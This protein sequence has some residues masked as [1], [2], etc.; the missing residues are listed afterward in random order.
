M[1]RSR[2][3]VHARRSD[4]RDEETEPES[5]A[6]TL[7]GEDEEKKIVTKVKRKCQPEKEHYGRF[8]TVIAHDSSGVLDKVHPP[9]DDDYDDNSH[10]HRTEDHQ[11]QC[12]E[13]DRR[14]AEALR[15]CG[16]L[17]QSARYQHW[18][19][20]LELSSKPV[21]LGSMPSSERGNGEMREV[22]V[23]HDCA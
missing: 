5:D 15:S 20:F 22:R 6:S 13:R 10:R 12:H 14:R 7:V 23:L 3:G 17:G 8:N 2:G 18:G 11:L 21:R 4:G 1:W 9:D 16:I 19:V